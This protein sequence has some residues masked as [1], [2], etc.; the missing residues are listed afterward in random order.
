VERMRH[1]HPRRISYIRAIARSRRI[2]PTHASS[3]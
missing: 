2:D 3:K 1:P